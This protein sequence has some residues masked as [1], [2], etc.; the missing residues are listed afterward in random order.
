MKGTVSIQ[1]LFSP[2]L[3][4]PA[5]CNTHARVPEHPLLCHFGSIPPAPL[6][7]PLDTSGGSPH[8]LPVP[9]WASSPVWVCPLLGLCSPTDPGRDG[10]VEQPQQCICWGYPREDPHCQVSECC[11][12]QEGVGPTLA[13]PI[14]QCVLWSAQRAGCKQF[15]I[16]Q[17]LTK[18][19][20]KGEQG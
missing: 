11:H 5:A 1:P 6:P 7:A 8:S 18:C 3:A 15:L 9:S 4:S 10:L 12:G 17:A 16:P 20:E 2:L 13:E 14:E 19:R